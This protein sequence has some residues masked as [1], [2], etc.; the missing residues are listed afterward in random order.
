MSAPF[1]APGRLYDVGGYRL[2]L[3]C[4]GQGHPAAI[5]DSGLGAN[6]IVW[7]NTLAAAAE[8]TRA[9]AFDRA[10]Y[11]WSE[12]APEHVQRTSRQIV[13]ELRILLEKAEVP[14]PYILVGHSFG[15]INMLVYAYAYPGEVAG[16]V[17][18]DP[19]H[20]E[21]FTRA[22]GVP[23]PAVVR[24]SYQAFDWMGRLGLLRWFGPAFAKRLLPEGEETLPPEAWGALL[25]F[26]SHSQDFHTAGREAEMGLENFA[27]ARGETGSLGDLPVIVLSADWWVR[28]K[29]TAMKR[30]LL[31]LREEQAKL[32][33]RAEHRIV[34]GCE[35]S[36]L[37]VV[38]PEAMAEAVKQI[39]DVV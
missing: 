12:P 31:K 18:V 33:S 20:P 26:A 28:G 23:S 34:A 14:P 32:S 19:S 25:A 4:Q 21:M 7:T 10:G 16:L 30:S 6:S 1:P 15:A 9:C 39:L 5:F 38:H 24:R 29:Q 8:H 3:Q 22:Q 27:Q 11:A 36:D 37:P 13:A 35:H 17:L 2:H